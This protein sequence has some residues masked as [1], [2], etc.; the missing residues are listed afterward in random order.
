MKSNIIIIFFVLATI[1]SISSCNK[2][3]NGPSV[4]FRSKVHRIANTWKYEN[5]V[6]NGVELA[7]NPEYQTLKQFWA[8]NGEMNTTS[9]NQV[10]GLASSVSG[11]W[12]LVDNDKKIRVTQNNVVQGIPDLV[13]MYTILK[14]ANNEMWLRSGDLST[15]IHLVPSK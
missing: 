11:K 12:E 15:D 4:S 8:P 5:Y 14:L 7:G 1:I 6:V 13:T 2:Y 9:I 10:T 3:E